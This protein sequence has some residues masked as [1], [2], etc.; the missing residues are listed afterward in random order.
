[1]ISR[2]V[3]SQSGQN[4]DTEFSATESPDPAAPRLVMLHDSFG[5]SLKPLLAEHFR[6]AAFFRT[7]RV[8][9][10]ALDREKP[11]VVIQ[12]IVERSLMSPPPKDALDD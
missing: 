8:S 3:L 11:D 4:G 2:T 7:P 1:M 6:R 5:D 9:L 10:Q 12:E